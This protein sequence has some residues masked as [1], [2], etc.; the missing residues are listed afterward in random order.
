MNKP[1]DKIMS[2]LGAALQNGTTIRKD[3]Q[4]KKKLEAIQAYSINKEAARKRYPELSSYFE[5]L[6]RFGNYFENI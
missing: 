5:E 2:D 1:S 3:E 4:Y 6:E